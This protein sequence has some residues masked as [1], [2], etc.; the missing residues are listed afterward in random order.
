MTDIATPGHANPEVFVITEWVAGRCD[1]PSL[2]IIE[3]PPVGFVFDCYGRG[4]SLGKSEGP[5]GMLTAVTA[6][7]KGAAAERATA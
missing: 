3:S 2:R 5:R 1:D 4:H 6:F 7:A